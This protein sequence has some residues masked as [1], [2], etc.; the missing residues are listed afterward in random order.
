MSQ[1]EERAQTPAA[2]MPAAHTPPAH[3][4]RTSDEELLGAERSV[5][6]STLTDAERLAR[7]GEEMA[8][9][10][11]E[12]SDIGRGAALF[13]SARTPE[14]DPE[15]EL[16]RETARTLGAAGFAILTGGGPGAME[17][18][19][20][21]AQEVG[22]LS[23][24]LNIDLPF[25][26]RSNP[27]IDRSLNFHYFFTRKVMF[28]RYSSAFVVLPGGYGTLDEL[29]E[30][31]TLIQTRKIKDFPVILLGNSYWRG[32]LD[33]IGERMLHTG[34]ISP[35]DV[36]LIQIAEDPVEVL[37]LVERAAMRQGRF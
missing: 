36:D 32:L 2:H 22:A 8:Y 11:K 19:N 33:W 34:K 14:E 30:A 27:Y 7:M 4:P 31:L 15:Y 3:T 12:L 6:R 35:A 16:A 24:G 1:E 18:A 29:F 28:V 10:F 23:V 25:E 26:Q 21:G 17:A 20:R 37:M 9:G 13:G 5:V